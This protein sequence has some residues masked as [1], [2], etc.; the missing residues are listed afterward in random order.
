M[1]AKSS[2]N[3]ATHINHDY[4]LSNDRNHSATQSYSYSFII[5]NLV[6]S[7]LHFQLY[8][9]LTRV[10]NTVTS[11]TTIACD[12]QRRKSHRSKLFHLRTAERVVA[13]ITSRMLIHCLPRKRHVPIS[14][15]L[16]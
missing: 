14:S 16:H 9:E 4:Y 11:I 7:K 6:I 12:N 1:I 8:F 10:F 15:K 3:K 13:W 5:S 2:F